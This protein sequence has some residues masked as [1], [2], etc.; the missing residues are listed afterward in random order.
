[1][2]VLIG[3][4]SL[5]FRYSGMGAKEAELARIMAAIDQIQNAGIAV[6]GCLIV[7]GDGETRASLTE[8]SRFIRATELADVQVTLSTPFPG[9]PLR[10]RLAREGR[11]LADGGWSNYT[12][13]DVTFKPDQLSV[14]E[15]E[16]GYRELLV[17]LF[18]VRESRRRTAIRHQIWRR[19]PALRRSTWPSE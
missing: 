6:N 13:F 1:V 12:L 5:V 14:A 8:L 10:S 11:L 2:Q 15:L 16:T 7:G 18:D 17:E 4:E 19:N 9:T 3:I